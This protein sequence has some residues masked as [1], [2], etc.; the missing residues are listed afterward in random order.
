MIDIKVN[1]E[2]LK[3]LYL[4]EIQKRLDQIELEA[5]LMDTKQ[6]CKMLSLSWPTVQKLFISDPN[7]PKFRVGAK[8]L[9]HRKQVEAYIDRWSSE[10][11]GM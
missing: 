2:E 8:W 11:E 3:A 6:L 7:F 9:F 10:K 4:D 1:Q 5:L